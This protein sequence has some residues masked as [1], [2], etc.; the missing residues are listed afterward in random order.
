[1][2]FPSPALA[3]VWSTAPSQIPFTVTGPSPP[4]QALQTSGCYLTPIHHWTHQPLG[5]DSVTS[6][7]DGAFFHNFLNT[8]TI[9]NSVTSIGIAA[10][11]EN[12]LT[13]VRIP[14]SVISLA[15]QAFLD[16]PLLTASVH[17]DT[18]LGED[19]FPPGTEIEYRGGDPDRA[20]LRRAPDEEAD[21]APTEGAAAE[22]EPAVDEEEPPVEDEPVVEYEPEESGETQS[23]EPE[24]EPADKEGTAPG[25]EEGFETEY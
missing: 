23:G 8:V 21:A 20:M 7:G 12:Q 24:P 16:N 6:I 3:L 5:P 14:D 15:T 13:S 19:V 4:G 11:R 17:V 1:M 10:F 9:G 2:W 18:V 22:D 25:D